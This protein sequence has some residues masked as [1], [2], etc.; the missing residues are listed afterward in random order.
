MR[1]MAASEKRTLARSMTDATLL[2]V[3]TL[4]SIIC[5]EMWMCWRLWS[6]C[7]IGTDSAHL[8]RICSLTKLVVGID[9]RYLGACNVRQMVW[10]VRWLTRQPL[11]ILVAMQVSRSFAD[12]V[13]LSAWSFLLLS[14][15]TVLQSSV[16]PWFSNHNAS[17]ATLFTWS[18]HR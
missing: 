4:T 10:H 1:S 18:W 13:L 3:S 8:N 17:C 14:S 16:N 9:P 15:R 11:Q 7:H 6:N 12:V 5:A 2:A